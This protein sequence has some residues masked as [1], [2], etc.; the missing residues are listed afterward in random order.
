VSRWQEAIQSIRI[1][2]NK[3]YGL[4]PE[5]ILDDA[6]VL[7]PDVLSSSFARVDTGVMPSLRDVQSE[8][9]QILLIPQ[10]PESV[11]ETFR[12][13]KRLH[14]FGRFEYGFYSVSQHYASL[15]MEAGLLS[16][17]TASLPNPVLVEAESFRQKMSKPSHSEL[18]EVCFKVGRK[19]RVDGH[20]FPHS[21]TK[22]LRRLRDTAI[23]NKATD[24]GISVVIGIRNDLSHHEFSTVL[25]PSTRTLS[26]VAELINT[27]FDRLPCTAA[28]LC[29]S[30]TRIQK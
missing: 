4:V 9:A 26:L 6:D 25:P 17:W 12:I 11:R 24:D 22:V 16:R 23:I 20:P 30:S 1:D 21:P 8:L 28:S 19:L 29:V 18:A 27:L 13:A 7:S 10:V 14:I 5:P 2:F 3:K 15:A